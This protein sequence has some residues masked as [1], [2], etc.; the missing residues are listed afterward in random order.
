MNVRA[1][2]EYSESYLNYVFALKD[3][4][5]IHRAISSLF[6]VALYTQGFPHKLGAVLESERILYCI[7]ALTTDSAQRLQL[8]LQLCSAAQLQLVLEHLRDNFSPES[9]ETSFY[10][11][12]QLQRH[13]NSH[14][15][16]NYHGSDLLAVLGKSASQ[17]QSAQF[18]YSFIFQEFVKKENALL[19]SGIEK[20]HTQLT[21]TGKL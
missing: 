19:Q 1:P 4:D 11:V 12:K 7:V 15:P 8:Y 18:I 6:D 3:L 17:L 20:T 2:S 21:K 13:K 10:R 9:L 16:L 5:K 14:E